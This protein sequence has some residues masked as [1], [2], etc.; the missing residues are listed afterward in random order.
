MRKAQVGP[1]NNRPSL[2]FFVAMTEFVL[3][4]SPAFADFGPKL[5][6]YVVVTVPYEGEP[7]EGQGAVAALLSLA[8]EE[9][10]PINMAVSVRRLGTSG[11]VRALNT[12]LET[13]TSGTGYLS[14]HSVTRKPS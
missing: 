6:D 3:A 10:E 11:F 7:L 14:R 8:S 12:L 2:Q 9:Q 1:M 5:P 13:E 4:A